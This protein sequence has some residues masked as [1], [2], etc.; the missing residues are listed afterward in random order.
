MSTDRLLG[1]VDKELKVAVEGAHSLLYQQHLSTVRDFCI[2]R[3]TLRMI[4][5]QNSSAFRESS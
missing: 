1:V 3:S 5:V 4:S 2:E